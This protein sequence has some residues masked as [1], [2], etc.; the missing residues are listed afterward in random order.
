M[1]E[2]LNRSRVEEAWLR[3]F[4]PGLPPEWRRFLPSSTQSGSTIAMLFSRYWHSNRRQPARWRSPSCSSRLEERR[5]EC[6]PSSRLLSSR[7]R[8]SVEG[9]AGATEATAGH[10]RGKSTSTKASW[11]TKSRSSKPRFTSGKWSHACRS[12]SIRPVF[13]PSVK[14]RQGVVDSG[15]GG[16]ARRDHQ[17]LLRPV[18][19]RTD[20]R[21]THPTASV[22]SPRRRRICRFELRALAVSPCSPA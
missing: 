8:S 21:M 7:T 16:C 13:G 20:P 11:T 12:D 15:A 9:T 19:R 10:G 4:S 3:T 1:A 18:L 5:C 6:G 22:A 2:A 17:S 14:A